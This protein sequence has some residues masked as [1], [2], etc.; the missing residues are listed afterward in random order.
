MN[1]IPI[2][3][4]F[5][6][7]QL[8]RLIQEEVEPDVLKWDEKG[9]FPQP[10]YSKLHDLGIMHM[11]LP[12]DLGGGGRPMIDLNCVTRRWGHHAP[13]L[14]AGFIANYLVL[15]AL[16]RFARPEIAREFIGELAEMKGL[17]SFCA[18]EREHGT[19]L[20]ASASM[21]RP[22]TGGYLLNGRKCFITNIN[23]S[24]HMIVLAQVPGESPND[25]SQLTAFC[26]RKSTPGIR[27]G[28]PLLMLGQRESNT[29]QVT[30][31]DVFV[32]EA[33][34]VGVVGGAGKVVAAALSRTRGMIAAMSVGVCDRAEAEALRHLSTARRFGEPLLARKDILKVI[35]ALRIEAEAAWLLACRAGAVWD[36]KGIALE[37]AGMAKC[38]GAD[39]AVRFTSEM[40]E[41]VGAQGYLGD[42][43]L[44]KLYRD[45]K[46]MEIYEGSTLV[47][48]TLIERERYS[49]LLKMVGQS[50]ATSRAA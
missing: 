5:N 41:L 46:A 22:V 13:G 18:T 40:I 37:E 38:F 6:F 29:G 3:S 16:S 11:G 17:S 9:I 26:L 14:G 23:Y 34:V 8:D 45:A 24:S 7:E 33:Q 28:E 42:S 15:T 25:R 31:E 27:V 32:P 4:E 43:F 30:F 12:R 19:D 36:E 2:A 39:L 35:S 10:V 47:Q 48:Q 1:T 44:A 50:R 21:A 49:D 20:F